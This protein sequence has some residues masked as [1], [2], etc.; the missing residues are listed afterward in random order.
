ML[1]IRKKRPFDASTKRERRNEGT[2][3]REKKEDKKQE[4]PRNRKENWGV[5]PTEEK[6]I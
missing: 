2:T 3:V 6:K 1:G 5:A 4:M